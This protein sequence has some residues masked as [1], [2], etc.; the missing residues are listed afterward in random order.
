M[1]ASDERMTNLTFLT[2]VE[3]VPA[4]RLK[5]ALSSPEMLAGRPINQKL[6]I[7]R[8]LTLCIW[9]DATSVVRPLLEAGVLR[10]RGDEGCGR[11]R[12]ANQD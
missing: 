11:L 5:V 9:E 2:D 4:R 7:I 3:E 10:G 6:A 8:C 1:G 12:G